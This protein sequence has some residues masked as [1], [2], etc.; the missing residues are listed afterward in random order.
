MT[1]YAPS[2]LKGY[3]IHIYHGEDGAYKDAAKQL[4]EALMRAFPTELT[5][6]KNIGAVGPHQEP[7]TSID[8]CSLDIASLIFWLAFK[9]GGTLSILLHPNTGDDETDHLE[10]SVWFNRSTE[11]NMTFFENLRS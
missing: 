8:V 5:R 3:H 6:A 10:H 4:T 2:N 9:S 1:T 7:N 11:Y